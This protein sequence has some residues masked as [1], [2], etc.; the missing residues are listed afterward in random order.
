LIF[1][2]AQPISFTCGAAPLQTP[3][4][5]QVPPAPRLYSGVL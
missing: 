4:E 1:S 3:R 2:K 5:G